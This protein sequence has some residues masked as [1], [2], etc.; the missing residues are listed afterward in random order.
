M[1]WIQIEDPVAGLYYECN[2]H[3][4]IC[5]MQTYHPDPIQAGPSKTVSGP[6]PGGK[7][8]RQHED[9]G[10]ETA[11]GQ[12]VHAYRDT[13]TIIAGVM[14][15]DKEMTYRREVRYAPHLGFNLASVLESPAVGVQRFAV[16]EIVTTEPEARWFRPPEG[17]RIVEKRKTLTPV[18]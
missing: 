5:E 1:S 10:S 14:G 15:N 4:K 13:V 18:Q 9:L 3:S 11:A 7:G 8:Y 17:Y 6:L 12:P 16:T 2:P